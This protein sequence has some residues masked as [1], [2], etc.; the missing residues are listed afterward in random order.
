M[1]IDR[2]LLNRLRKTEPHDLRDMERFARDNIAIKNNIWY[3]KKILRAVLHMKV[4][5]G[6]KVREIGYGGEI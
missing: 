4:L 6:P 1:H 3:W 2:K 5:K